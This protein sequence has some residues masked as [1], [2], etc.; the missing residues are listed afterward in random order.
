MNEIVLYSQQ[1]IL[2]AGLFIFI[3]RLFVRS[4][5]AYNWNRFYLLSTMIV[6]L[7]LPYFNIS[8]WF[9]TEKPIIFHAPAIDFS[10]A[11]T[12]TPNVTSYQPVQIQNSFSLSDLIITAYSIIAIMLIVRFIWG[13][14]RIYKMARSN[15]F[16]KCGILRLY[17]IKL[18]TTF[19][20]FNYIFIQ[21]EH[22]E[23]PSIDYI[24]QHEKA[25]V[26]QLH[27]ID[28]LLTELILVFGWFNPF[29]YVYRHDLHLL[30]ECQADQV[31][32]NSGYDKLTY[33]Q[34]LLNEVSGNLT[35]NIVNQFSYSLIKRRFKMISKNQ[36]SRLAGFR[37]LLAVPTA[38]ALLMLF[39]FTSLEK[40]TS[41]IKSNIIQ[42]TI[43]A[44]QSSIDKLQNPLQ[45]T[46]STD[47]SKSKIDADSIKV[48]QQKIEYPKVDQS[49]LV[50]TNDGIDKY[51][52]GGSA[53]WFDY[54]KKNFK[55]PQEDAIG[56]PQ[57]TLGVSFI[58]S[59]TGEIESVPMRG[60]GAMN[61]SEV[62]EACVKEGLRVVSI[63]PKMEPIMKNGK[64]Q[65]VMFTLPIPLGLFTPRLVA[66]PTSYPEPPL[67]I[68][69][70]Q[71]EFKGG[72]DAMLKFIG[73][74][75]KYPQSA[76]ENGIQGTVY[77]R[78]VVD[79]SG[80][81]TNINVERGI[82]RGCDEEAVRIVQNMPDWNPGVS[83]GMPVNVN[84]VVIVKFKLKATYA[85]TD[86]SQK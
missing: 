64:A 34:L 20:F 3:Y 32:I 12:T 25:H 71:P 40:T 26:K 45:I 69:E 39:S 18:K 28:N 53:A 42:P 35:Y 33:H 49:I 1:T 30:H 38:F 50:K 10:Q 81:L 59:E 24:I 85:T 44:V 51:F 63:M 80:K 74:N 72:F 58:V 46:E 47:F 54:L 4:S 15:D 13:L 31:V 66:R 83:K 17:P 75:M 21:P 61:G 29:Y 37:I 8:G 68:A 57:G 77:V 86:N 62:D 79:K 16:R 22:W 5:N 48:K 56:G 60:N 82:G 9:I 6:S 84:Q 27:S 41:L 76:I 19:S 65:R 78:F 7:F 2:S 14:L 70:K 73:D 55:Y 67:E 43:H 36:K 52:P 23:K 11:I